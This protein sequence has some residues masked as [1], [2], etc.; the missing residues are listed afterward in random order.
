MAKQPAKAK[1]T[2]VETTEGTAVRRFSIA[3]VGKFKKNG[4]VTLPT[5]QFADLK[6]AGLVRPKAEPTS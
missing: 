1:A 2:E 3:H 6:K 5:N 4:K